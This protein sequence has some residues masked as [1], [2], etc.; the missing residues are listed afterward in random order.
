MYAKLRDTLN[1]ISKLTFTKLTNFFGLFFTFYVSRLFR[2]NLICGMPISASIE[3]T[4]SCNLQCSECPSGQRN[5]NRA[6]GMLNFENFK[7]YFDGLK[8]ELIY[9]N[10]YFQG[11][12]LLNKE[13]C[14][15]VKYA[16]DSGI[17]TSTST[18]AHF[19]NT[20]VSE[21]IVNSGLDRLIISID[22]ATA[23]SYSIYR[24][25]GTFEK[26]IE[27]TK[28]ILNARNKLNS[29]KPY[30]IWQFIIFKHNEHEIDLIKKMANEYQVDKLKFKTAQIY[31]LSNENE[32]LLPE[33]SKYSR[34]EK[35]EGF[36]I[37]NRLMNHCWRMWQGCV[38]TWNGYVVP[39]CFDKDAEYKF[40]KIENSNFTEIWKNDKYKKFRKEILKSRKNIDICRNCS[41]GSKIWI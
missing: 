18:N 30:I 28:N 38:I 29:L 9:L 25:G 26:V 36:K 6:T 13:F 23:Q 33:N 31:N 24:K 37:K 17:Y 40:G 27:G 15:M 22:G 20:K 12:P 2:K 4:T 39:C 10:I 41:E 16:G 35:N 11:E 19:L 21:Q 3:P 8:R 34:Y 1:L 32:A 14:K 5:F 7:I